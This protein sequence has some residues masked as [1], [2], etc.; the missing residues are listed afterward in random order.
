MIDFLKRNKYGRATFLPLTAIN[1]TSGIR[2]PEALQ[3]K[4]L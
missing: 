3:E 4:G 2:Q 1:G